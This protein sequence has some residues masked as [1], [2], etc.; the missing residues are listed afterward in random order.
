MRMKSTIAVF[1]IANLAVAAVI[2]AITLLDYK[3]QRNNL[4][5]S[6]LLT[7]RFM[8]L[9]K[10][11]D[12]SFR[13]AFFDPSPESIAEIKE[14]RAPKAVN[15]NISD[16]GSRVIEVGLYSEA[17]SDLSPEMREMMAAPGNLVIR[18][19]GD[20]ILISQKLYT[21]GVENPYA[22]V[23]IRNTPGNLLERTFLKSLFYFVIVFVMINGQAA[24]V[25]A[26]V[27]GRREVVYQKGY[28]KEH[29]IGALKIHHKILGDILADHEESNSKDNRPKAE[30]VPIKPEDR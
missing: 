26:V 22:A 28:L 30:I 11:Y 12:H 15:P 9:G 21:K 23:M 16:V 29:A 10:E 20:E 17:S 18:D 1:I 7:L 25:L 6:D 3:S 4:I 8:T 2:V 5:A 13:V 27:R 19:H 24:L 14:G